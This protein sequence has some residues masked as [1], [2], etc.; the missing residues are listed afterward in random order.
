VGPGE[1]GVGAD[2]L[3]LDP[4]PELHV[5]APYV[6]DERVQAV[7]PHLLVDVPVP[8][9]G[10]VTASVAEPTVVED[11]ALDPDL[12]RQVGERPE[13][14]HVVIEVDRL[15][16]VEDDRPGPVVARM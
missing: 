10:G 6:V 3:G 7:R 11:E 4:Q 5:E 2:H 1:I 15:P 16:G 14:V 12:R 8:Q 9:A 13:P